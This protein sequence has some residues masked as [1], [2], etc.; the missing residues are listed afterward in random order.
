VTTRNLPTHERMERAREARRDNWQ[1]AAKGRYTP[2]TRSPD[3]RWL[4]DL[5]NVAQSRRIEA[6]RR[7]VQ[8]NLRIPAGATCELAWVSGQPFAC[9]RFSDGS[10]LGYSIDPITAQPARI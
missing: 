1:P 5:V 8:A 4:Q 2:D 9:V 3:E 10:H 7:R 6:F